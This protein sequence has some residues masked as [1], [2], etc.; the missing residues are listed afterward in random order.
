MSTR[1]NVDREEIAR[2]WNVRCEIVRQ[3]EFSVK[4]TESFS[5]LLFFSFFLLGIDSYSTCLA[6]IRALLY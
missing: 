6:M 3:R 2:T 5:I 1:G 4:T